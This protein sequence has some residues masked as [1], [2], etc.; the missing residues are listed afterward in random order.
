MKNEEIFFGKKLKELRLKH[1]EMGLHNFHKAMGTTLKVSDLFDIEHGY[2][3]PPD[4][5]RFMAQIIKVLDIP[6]DHEDWVELEKL[7]IKPFIMQKKNENVVLSLLTHKSDGSRL[8]E[9][10]FK[11]LH[12]HINNIAKEHNKK[13]D[14]YNDGLQ[15]A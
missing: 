11:N 14:E 10:E 8:T 13:A 7:K 6:I 2:A 3:L 1:A 12:D 4:C 5:G 15:R 9:E